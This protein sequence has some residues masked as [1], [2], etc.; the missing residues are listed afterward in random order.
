MKGTA[1]PGFC[2]DHECGSDT[3]EV[4]LLARCVPVQDLRESFLTRE[5]P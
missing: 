5:A 3:G 4:Q 1:G 2:E